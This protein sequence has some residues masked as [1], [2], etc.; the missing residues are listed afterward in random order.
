[1]P[2]WKSAEKRLPKPSASMEAG[3]NLFAVR[4]TFKV[5]GGDSVTAAVGIV[6]RDGE[7]E[8]RHGKNWISYAEP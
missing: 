1:M 6:L 5:T 2:R 4:T 3:S 8:L 7:D